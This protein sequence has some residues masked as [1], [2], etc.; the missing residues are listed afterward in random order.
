[1]ASISVSLLLYGWFSLR[2]FVTHFVIAI[3][4]PS[5]GWLEQQTTTITDVFLIFCDVKQV[6]DFTPEK[7]TNLMKL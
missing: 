4:V 5:L 2:H 6:E 3:W 7:A 1:M